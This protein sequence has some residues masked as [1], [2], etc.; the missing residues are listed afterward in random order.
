MDSRRSLSDA[1]EVHLDTESILLMSRVYVFSVT[2]EDARLAGRPRNLLFSERKQIV[3]DAIQRYR[4]GH[5]LLALLRAAAFALGAL[6]L[7]LVALWLLRRSYARLSLWQSERLSKYGSRTGRT[8]S[9]LRIFEG[10][11]RMLIRIALRLAFLALGL[12]VLFTA[13]SVIFGLF[14]AT[15]GFSE[16]AVS[17]TLE[18][19]RKM[20]L[21]ILGYLPNFVVLVAVGILTYAA[22]RICR[23]LAHAIETGVIT[24]SGFH[25]EWASPTYGLARILLIMFGLV[26][27]FPYFP[28]GDS[29]AL[30]GAS[31]FIGVLVS[32]GSGS[33]MGNVI[34][35][36][37]LT[38]MRPFRI[39]DRV[40]IADTTGDIVEK[41]LLVT[42]I[43]TIKNVEMIVPNSAVL[44]AHITNYSAYAN[45]RGLILNTTVTIGYDVPWRTVHELMIRAA[46]RTAGLLPEPRPFVLQTSLNDSHISYEINAYTDQANR[47]AEIYSELHQH[48]Q[49]EFNQSGVEIMSPMYLSVRDGNTVTIPEAHRPP[50]YKPPSFRVR[51]TAAGE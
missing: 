35:G 6:A 2:D 32:L 31:I 47:M 27:A 30:R 34:A 33:A 26:V 11:V 9:L 38:Y 37:I 1:R 18:V 20:A 5:S 17:T 46:L 43:R 25:R 22:I 12:L 42:R 40:R 15:A 28:G 45:D 13:A 3:L 48:I 51:D 7:A 4:A 23:G 36:V 39:G 19:L 10:P 14:P 8:A 44:G 49:E 16:A 41:S 24:I 29:P 50:G 21:D